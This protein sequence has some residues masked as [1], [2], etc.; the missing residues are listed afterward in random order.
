MDPSASVNKLVVVLGLQ[1]GMENMNTAQAL[2]TI[3][4]VLALLA[5]GA[6]VAGYVFCLGVPQRY[7]TRGLALALLI[8][9][10]TNL[11]ITLLMKMLPISGAMDLVIVPL[12]GP[13]ITMNE[14]GTER[15]VPFHAFWSGSPY[16]EML[17]AIIIQAAFYAEPILFC[18]FLR[19]VALSLK[20]DEVLEP[21][22]L[23]LLRLGFG[24]FFILLSFYLLSMAGTSEVM[25]LVLI[26]FYL[27]WHGFLLG[28]IIYFALSMLKARQ[29]IAYLLGEEDEDE[30]PKASRKR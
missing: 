11:F 27:L 26:V 24:Q 8:L 1:A 12:L 29:R 16:W 15:L 17:A 13:D 4:Y 23:T 22:A 21:R 6:F 30:K 10:S 20:D 2:G 28:F 14:A 9:G 19:A 18:V 3:E 25:R 5:G 7:G